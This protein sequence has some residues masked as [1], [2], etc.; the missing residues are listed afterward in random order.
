MKFSRKIEYQVI[1]VETFCRNLKIQS[2]TR[3]YL[4]RLNNRCKFLRLKFRYNVEIKVTNIIH[5]F[6]GKRVI[7]VWGGFIDLTSTVSQV[8]VSRECEGYKRR[9]ISIVLFSL[10]TLSM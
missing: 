1:C 5:E 2:S 10:H 3:H 6:K 8:L 4:G 9:L 7:Y